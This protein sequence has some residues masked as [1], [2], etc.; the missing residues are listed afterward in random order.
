MLSKMIAN[1]KGRGGHGELPETLE[2]AAIVDAL[3]GVEA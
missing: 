2:Q 3:E 1:V